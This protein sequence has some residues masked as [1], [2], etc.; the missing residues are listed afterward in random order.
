MGRSSLRRRGGLALAEW[1]RRLGL[2]LRLGLCLPLLGA[3][4]VMFERF[5]HTGSKLGC[6]STR[7]AAAFRVGFQTGIEGRG[8]AYRHTD[9]FA[10]G[11]GAYWS[12]TWASGGLSG[13]VVV[14][15]SR[16]A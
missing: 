7:K 11:T 16:G 5:P 6:S 1:G 4:E 14:S 10:K 9:L 8:D 2:R 12:T 3:D 15:S 13:H